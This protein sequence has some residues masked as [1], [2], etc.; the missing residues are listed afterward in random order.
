MDTRHAILCFVYQR[1]FLLV[2]L[3]RFEQF[4][5]Q[6][7]RSHRYALMPAS[8]VMLSRHPFSLQS[9]CGYTQARGYSRVVRAASFHGL[10]NTSHNETYNVLFRFIMELHPRCNNYRRH[11][12]HG[13][14]GCPLFAFPN[15]A[16]RWLSGWC[17]GQ[18]STDPHERRLAC[19]A[20][21]S[22][23][24]TGCVLAAADRPGEIQ[25]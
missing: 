19:R 3:H 23:C 13:T 9:Q 7:E 21:F 16:I 25:S 17:W 20:S 18:M 6:K 14:S 2:C 5:L 11:T 12:Q 4:W 15:D 22:I 10:A 24:C 1:L 8:Y